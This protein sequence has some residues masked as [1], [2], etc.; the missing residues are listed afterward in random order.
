MVF[1]DAITR[2]RHSR[3]CRS[4]GFDNFVRRRE[5]ET[6]ALQKMAETLD[7]D[8]MTQVAV[9]SSNSGAGNSK[10]LC[11]F[12][13]RQRFVSL[14]EMREHVKYPCNKPVT[15][16]RSSVPL[17]FPEPTFGTGIQQHYTDGPFT[18]VQ[19]GSS[20]VTASVSTSS[21]D[22]HAVTVYMNE[23]EQAQQMDH[24]GEAKPTNIYVNEKGETVIEVE[25]LDLN[26][27]SGELSLAHLLTQLS[28]QGIVF[29]QQPQGDTEVITQQEPAEADFSQPTAVDAANTLTQLAGSA[30]RA[31]NNSQ[32]TYTYAP[33]MKH[34]KTENV[35]LQY[36]VEQPDQPQT[37]VYLQKEEP[38][39]DSTHEKYIICTS[40]SEV[41]SVVRAN[42]VSSDDPSGVGVTY[43]NGQAQADDVQS[44]IVEGGSEQTVLYETQTPADHSSQTMGVH[45]TDSATAQVGL[46]GGSMIMLQHGQQQI[47]ATSTGQLIKAEDP[48]EQLVI[49]TQDTTTVEQP[50]VMAGEAHYA[51][52]DRPVTVMTEVNVGQE[53]EDSKHCLVVSADSQGVTTAVPSQSAVDA[54]LEVSGE[55]FVTKDNHQATVVVPEAEPALLLPQIV[56]VSSSAPDAQQ[57]LV[58]QAQSTGMMMV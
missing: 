38:M 34:I 52:E 41:I 25:N 28:Q 58:Q 55:S 18:Q 4:G 3:T 13:C 44:T 17:V 49:T 57:I 30:Y 56:S 5:I 29:D 35:E 45:T 48:S 37:Q 11:C 8:M 42:N 6:Q 9:P 15:L 14:D 31:V 24:E 20:T 22:P 26:T 47:L 7:P 32:E 36:Q 16:P 54:L 21:G 12:I 51:N 2:W 39:G 23:G 50:T 40:E 46:P 27:K 10:E 53:E 33:P 43:Q 1:E 19:Q